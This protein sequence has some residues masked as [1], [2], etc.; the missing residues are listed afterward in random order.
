MAYTPMQLAEAFIHAGELTDALKALDDALS[1][2]P[3]D[4]RARSLRAQVLAR[5][6]DGGALALA[7][8]AQL[9]HP[10]PEDSLLAARLH[11]EAGDLP[12][13][14]A[15]L[16][17]GLSQFVGEPRLTE[18]LLGLL[19]A[20]GDLERARSLAESLPTDD[21]R[22]CVWRGDLAADEGDE[23]AALDHYRA[24]LAQIDTRYALPDAPASVLDTPTAE[25]LPSPLLGAQL[26]CCCAALIS[27]DEAGSA[28][29]PGPPMRGRRCCFP[30]RRL[31]R[32][33]RGG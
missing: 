18:G 3:E 30:A 22:W 6:P 24:A 14:I 9:M 8:L 16:D 10:H 4:D 15:A 7:D 12:S 2:A 27:C 29:K 11:A 1:A 33:I 23:T 25:A 19:R 31:S 13:A 26:I 17:V 5:M 32:S 21:W 20:A 28:K